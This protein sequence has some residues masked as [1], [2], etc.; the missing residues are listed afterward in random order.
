MQNT[1]YYLQ[2]LKEDFSDRQKKSHR[3]S[4]R[5]YARD[6]GIHPSTLS[7]VLNG[8]RA[9]PEKD[10]KRIVQKMRLGP[11]EKTLFYESLL[12]GRTS[13]DAIKISEDDQRFMLD[14]SYFNVIS[15]WEHYALLT[16][17]DVNDFKPSLN[18][19]ST[20]MK[21]SVTRAEVVI[22]NLINSGLLTT[23]PKGLQKTHVKVRT[24]EDV[25]SN[26]LQQSHLE[27]LEL[28][29][30]KLV[31]VDVD[32]RDF[33]SM[34]LAVDTDKIPEAK[35]IIREFRQKMA[36]LMEK[37]KKKEVFQLAIQFYPLTENRINRG[38]HET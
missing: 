26:A 32:L 19:I 25:T 16:L 1:P 33:S 4:L 31:S 18:E 5:A 28:G 9:L 13:L 6:T 36:A 10:S 23:G 37:G 17:F 11:K 30:E 35:I 14:E 7:L 12:K 20:R 34:N 29:K 3:Y 2:K 38:T 21:I 27:T 22:Q 15:E 8:K 24:T